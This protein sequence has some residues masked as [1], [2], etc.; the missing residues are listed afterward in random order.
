MTSCMRS[1][2]GR[3]R[4]GL[5]G[6]LEERASCSR[7][8]W[9]MECELFIRLGIPMA[10]TGIDSQSLREIYTVITAGMAH[11]RLITAY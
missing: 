9:E 11:Y 2:R 7:M 4:Q 1:G 5:E 8:E 6:W 3:G 10:G